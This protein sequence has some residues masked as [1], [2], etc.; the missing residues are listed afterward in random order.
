ME[1]ELDVSK[2]WNPKKMKMV[3]TMVVKLHLPIDL[4]LRLSELA[5][6]ENTTYG[7]LIVKRVQEFV[8]NNDK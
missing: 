8:A 3:P 6:R 1:P 2:K 7:A 4:V 5:E